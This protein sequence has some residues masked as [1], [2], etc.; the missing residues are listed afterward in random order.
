MIVGFAGAHRTGKT[1]LAQKVAEKFNIPLRLTSMSQVFKEVGVGVNDDLDF[2]TRMIVQDQMLNRMVAIF[3]AYGPFVTDRTPLDIIAY[4]Y[5]TVPKNL[6]PEQ[7]TI[8]QQHVARAYEACK[9]LPV[10][11]R[12]P[13]GIKIVDDPTKAFANPIYIEALDRMIFGLAQDSRLKSSC[14][15]IERH[16][17]DLDRRVELVGEVMRDVRQK[18][19]AR[20]EGVPLH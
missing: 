18:M 8:V 13:P 12:I 16:I 19:T 2:D 17:T 5:M 20:M 7:A 11:V 14:W 3:S 6:T 9:L 10:I 4:T 15:A 1:T